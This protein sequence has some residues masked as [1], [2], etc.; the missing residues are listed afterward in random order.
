[1]LTP[2]SMFAIHINSRALSPLRAL[3]AMFDDE[4]EIPARHM[5]EYFAMDYRVGADSIEVVTSGLD[6]PGWPRVPDDTAG[7]VDLATR[8]GNRRSEEHTSELKS[9]M[10]ISNTRYC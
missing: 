5:T 6:Q 8:E 4:D 3:R 9:L 2:E 10:R 7:M 1:M